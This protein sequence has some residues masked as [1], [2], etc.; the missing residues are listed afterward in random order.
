MELLGVPVPVIIF[1]VIALGYMIYMFF[2][3]EFRELPFIIENLFYSAGRRECCTAKNSLLIR[4]QIHVDVDDD[5]LPS[6]F[7]GCQSATHRHLKY[8]CKV[9]GTI[10]CT[11]NP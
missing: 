8:K 1:L 3:S 10:W 4:E 11:M 6:I 7:I 2:G 9:C 5:V